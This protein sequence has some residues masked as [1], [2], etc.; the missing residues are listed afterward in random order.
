MKWGASATKDA[1]ETDNA[2][3]VPVPYN[4]LDKV[5]NPKGGN[6]AVVIAAPGVGKTTFLLN[7]SV[8]SGARVL[9]ISSD[10]SPHDFTVQLACLSTGEPRSIVEGR[11]RSS[12]T[13]REEY[14]RHISERYPN[15]VLD[16]SPRPTMAQIRTKAMAL[17]E[18]WGEAPEMIVMDTASNVAMSDMADNAEWQR[19]WLESIGIAREFNSF[20]VFAHHVKVG[21]ARTG[22]VAPEMSDGLWGCD[23]FPEFVFGLHSPAARQMVCTV[24]K[25]RGGRKD[26]PVAFR[27]E[28]STAEILELERPEG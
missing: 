2:R 16:F 7:W 15:L 9:Y 8:R 12:D 1:W 19:V 13:W 28:F 3:P 27:A 22:R 5:I 18:L 10:T 11:L 21:P 24:R 20:F 25:N 26:V 4:K 23:Q 6:V 14:A 17:T